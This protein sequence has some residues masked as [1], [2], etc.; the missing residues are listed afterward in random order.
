LS[1]LRQTC[2]KLTGER[3]S[4][5][6]NFV[7]TPIRQPGRQPH[8]LHSTESPMAPRVF[9]ER[10][11]EL[12]FPKIWPE[13]WRHDEFGIRDLPEQKIAHAQFA[14]G[15]DDQIGIWILVRVE[16]LRDYLL[17]DLGR[18]QLS[19]FRFRCDGA[20]AFHDFLPAAVTQRENERQPVVLRQR[21]HRFA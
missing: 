16:M 6:N 11:E 18:F 5:E 1:L 7:A 9:L 17:G 8:Y 15:A 19:G 10:L 4:R 14:T 13:R 2:R 21:S 3:K 12:P 20:N